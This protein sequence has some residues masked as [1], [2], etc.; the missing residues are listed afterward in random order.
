MLGGTKMTTTGFETEPRRGRVGPWMGIAFVVLFVA[1]FLTFPMPSTNSHRV[2]N[3]AKWSAWWTHSN[4][5][6]MAIVAA[7]LMV[8][9][10][11]AFVWFAT[12]LQQRLRER[13]DGTMMVGFAW[14]FA[15]LAIASALVRATIPG[16]WIFGSLTIP[17]GDLAAQ[18]DGIG[19][20]TLLVGGALSAGAFLAAACHATRRSV[21]FPAWLTTAGYVVAVLQFGAAF[22]FPFALFPLWV[23]VA[24]IV[25]LRRDAQ[26][27]AGSMAEGHPERRLLHRQRQ[28]KQ[29]TADL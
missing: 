28:P 18:L 2:S 15:A 10:A 8:L 14:L 9:G 3:V 17:S 29:P 16:G 13:S 26:F 4:H 25:L 19:E 12:S 22:F 11:L 1:G 21:V 27:R 5:R 6:V 24:S 7:Y 20:A 23:L